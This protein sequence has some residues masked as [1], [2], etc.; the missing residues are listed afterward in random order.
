MTS[1]T[2]IGSSLVMMALLISAFSQILLKLSARK[3]YQNVWQEYI[4]PFVITAYAMYFLTTILCV[5]ALRY[6][7]VTLSA[8]LDSAGQI[9]V[10]V[11]S[12]LFLREKISKRKC[13]GMLVIVIGII[14]FAI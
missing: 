12:Y 10:P 9:F 14:I 4:N 3:K 13:L 8:A 6:I 7:P 11:M 1:N 2:L 5:F